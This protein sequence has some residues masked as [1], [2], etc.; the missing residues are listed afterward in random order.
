MWSTSLRALSLPVCL[1]VAALASCSSS[2]QAAS[3]AGSDRGT[4]AAGG[5]GGRSAVH[6]C[7]SDGACSS[8]T[9]ASQYGAGGSGT[10]LPDGAA[11]VRSP[12]VCDG[13]DNDCDGVVDNGFTDQGTPVGSI[14]YS[15]GYGACIGMG[16]VTCT[17]PTTAGCSATST[18]AD[19]NFHTVAAPNGSWDWNCNN[20]VD[21]KYPLAACE[22][23]TA[24]TCPQYGWA[25]LP[26]QSG[27][28]SQMLTQS[29]CSA[30]AGGCVSTGAG[31][32][33]SEACK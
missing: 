7:G 31:Q 15:S 10:P 18:S 5:G 32:M 25:P 14:C 1:A 23:F 28:C 2:Q 19:E 16:R 26:G 33:V 30:T 12:E 21:R 24:A 6:V 29:A 13:K 3:D 20:N 22:S 11:C 4:Q 27:D 9:D 17:S 8:T